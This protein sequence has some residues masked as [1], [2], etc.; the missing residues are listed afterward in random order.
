[1]SLYQRLLGSPFVYNKVRP[2][3][4]GGIDMSASYGNLGAGPGDVVVDV[5]CGTGDALTYLAAFAAY[6]GFDTDEIALA[7]ARERA[8][9]RPDRAQIH[10]HARTFEVTD[11]TALAPTRV[12]LS[13][14][15][16]H[17]SDD[18][19]T[20]LLSLLART[21]S[22]VR[23]ATNDPVYLPGQTISNLFAWADRGKHVRTQGGYLSLVERAGLHVIK[24]EV[25]RSHP[26]RG[27][28]LYQL[29]ALERTAS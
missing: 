24:N 23:I 22:V 9:Q 7:H 29:M 4:V 13:G 19:A 11:A 28:A 20:A 25:V 10:L 12:M 26:T 6:H 5:G 2:L 15:L 27:R 16:H 14:L 3:V 18:E 21:P 17:L 1:V 8:T